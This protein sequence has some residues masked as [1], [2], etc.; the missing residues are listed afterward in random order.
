MR[1]RFAAGMLALA[2]SGASAVSLAAPLCVYANTATNFDYR[3]RVIALSGI[4]TTTGDLSQKITRAEF[5]RMLVR[6]SGYRSV[7]T[8]KSNVS[9]FADVKSGNEY[10][11]AIRIAAE[12]GWMTGY[13]GGNFKPDQYVTLNE[14]AKWVLYLLGYT[15]DDFSGDQFN[16]R[17]A[18]Y[19]DL[20]LNENIS[21]SD[22]TTVMT[23]SDCV[24]LFYNLMKTKQ[25]GTS[26]Y[27]GAAVLDA[28][29]DD[30][31]EVNALAMADNTTRGPKLAETKSD[32]DRIIPFDLDDASIF[33]DG[34]ETSKEGLYASASEYLVLYYSSS[35]KTIWAYNADE[36]SDSDKLVAHGEVEAIYY[37]ST[38]TLVPSSVTLDD[39]NTY[40]L[41]SSEVQFIFSVYGDVKVGDDV[42]LI[43]QRNSAGTTDDDDSSS[44][45]VVVDYV[46]P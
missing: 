20:D 25:K 24:N 39:G 27:Y 35:T 46:E 34:A 3:K 10:A 44:T 14:A 7:L 41:N 17:M 42:V 11:S 31:G 6:A 9:V 26:S 29:V 32:I 15:A 2:L 4:M 40:Q 18:E 30:D 8:D 28:D 22:P 21:Y 23:K 19:A 33:L 43:Y 36:S 1:S 12:Q 45:Y 38:D 16:K 5:A 13:L 37:N